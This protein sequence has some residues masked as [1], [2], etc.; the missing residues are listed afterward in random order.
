MRR[1]TF[2]GLLGGAAAT[3]PLAARAQ[4]ATMPV[5]GYLAVTSPEAFGSRLQAFR[6]GLFETGY[7]EGRNVTVEY[8]WADSQF[9]RLPALASDLVGRRPSTIVV[10]PVCLIAA[11]MA[12]DG[13]PRPAGAVQNFTM[14]KCAPEFSRAPRSPLSGS[15][16][17]PSASLQ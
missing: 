17:W 2:I 9:D 10:D 11:A 3:W 5:I 16:W 14:P 8:L 7:Q 15:P 6:Q 1:R 4:Q 12:I 13:A